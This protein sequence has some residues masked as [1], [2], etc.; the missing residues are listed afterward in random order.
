MKR[1][2]RPITNFRPASGELNSGEVIVDPSGYIPISK[3]VS[4]MLAAGVSLEASRRGQYYEY[5]DDTNEEDMALDPTTTSRFDP[6]DAQV[7]EEELM[8]RHQ[9]QLALDIEK[10]KAK[11]NQDVIENPVK[12]AD[13]APKD[14]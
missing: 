2:F 12:P 1:V 10:A 3:Q 4:D 11:E 5:E 7:L 8:A 6:V 9:A 14:A 13:D